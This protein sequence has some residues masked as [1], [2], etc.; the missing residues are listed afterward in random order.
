MEKFSLFYSAPHF[1]LGPGLTL[2]GLATALLVASGYLVPKV[3]IE[4]SD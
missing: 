4:T 3:F 2:F 1:P